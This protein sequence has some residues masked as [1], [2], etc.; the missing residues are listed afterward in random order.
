MVTSIDRHEA[1]V[2]RLD[3]A[4][5]VGLAVH[6]DMPV[7]VW[8]GVNIT[9]WRGAVEVRIPAEVGR[10]AGARDA[11]RLARASPVRAGR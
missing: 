8:P 6:V 3:E 11:P 7:T 5:Q 4:G 10:R 9:N 1:R 2:R